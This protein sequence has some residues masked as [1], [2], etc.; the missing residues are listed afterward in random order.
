M[1]YTLSPVARARTSIG[2]VIIIGTQTLQLIPRTS[3]E[4]FAGA[5]PI[6][7]KRRL[8]SLNRFPNHTGE[9]ASLL[10]FANKR[11]HVSEH[12]V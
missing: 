8:L 4:N 5:I 12:F 1:G 9:E 2:G 3:P 10:S 7:V 11:D 6:T